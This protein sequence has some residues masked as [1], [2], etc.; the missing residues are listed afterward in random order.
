M[1][2]IFSIVLIVVIFVAIYFFGQFL[3]QS[4]NLTEQV[5]YIDSLACSPA[6]SSCVTEFDE[7]DIVVRFLQQPSALKPFD[8]EVLTRGFDANKIS[9]TFVMNNMDMGFNFFNL[10]QQKNKIWRVKAILPVCSLARND[11]IAEVSIKYKDK[12]LRVDYAFE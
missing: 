4:E 1:N 5:V 12:I 8:V 9:V 11:W 10:E 3:H 2:N 7:G 6:M